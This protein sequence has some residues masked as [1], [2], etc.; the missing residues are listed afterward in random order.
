MAKEA[1][2]GSRVDAV[3]SVL[4]PIAS[5]SR[6]TAAMDTVEGARVIASGGRDLSPAQRVALAAGESGAKLSGAHAETTL[7]NHAAQNGLAPTRMSVSRNICPACKESIE[8]A[9][10]ML[11]S[12]TTVI[13]PR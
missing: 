7:L 11:T 12:P 3:H 13:W 2:L 1:T 5:R 10:G 4:D 9:G 8:K 6:T